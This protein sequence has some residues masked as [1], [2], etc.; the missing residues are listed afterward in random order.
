[1]KEEDELG[2]SR[3]EQGRRTDEEEETLKCQAQLHVC[4]IMSERSVRRMCWY[5]ER[6]TWITGKK[7]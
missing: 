7:K 4:I 3:W 2:R 6:E 5:R 1:M